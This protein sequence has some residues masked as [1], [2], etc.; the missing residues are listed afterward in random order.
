LLVD[1]A[2]PELP[3]FVFET[4]KK[5]FAFPWSRW[6][7]RG[8]PLFDRARHVC[9]D[10]EQ[11]VKLGISPSAISELWSHFTSNE[12]RLSALQVLAPIALHDYASR[13]GLYRV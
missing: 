6:L 5:G 2:G 13:Y 1:I 3:R 11:W 10:R 9:E 4:A 7:S 12:P 8:G